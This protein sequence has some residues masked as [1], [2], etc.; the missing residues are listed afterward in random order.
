MM[1]TE[2]AVVLAGALTE[3]AIIGL[4]FY[5]HIWRILPFFCSYCI[6]DVFSNVTG[7]VIAH[8]NPATYF[9]VYFAQMIVDSVWLFCVLVEL[10]W[11]VLR[12]VRASLPRSAL[13]VVAALI[14]LVGAAIWPFAAISGLAHPASRQWLIMM[15]L[16]RTVA[17]LRVLFFFLLAAGSQLLSISWRD[18]ELQVATGLGFYSLVNVVVSI[19]QSHQ[20]TG[21][22]Y[23]RLNEFLIVSY[24]C[25]L[26]YWLVSFSQKEA[27][28]RE[29]TPQMQSF[30]L[31]MAGTARTTRIA[32]SDPRVNPARKHDKL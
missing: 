24:L 22:Q 28:R 2:N 21:S 10:A 17:I 16:Q 29:F 32:V 9:H 23:I 8:Y 6:W 4:L 20:S 27:E 18:R 30:L 7:D 19:L 11:S 25:S 12:P 3:I 31:A 14:L 1:S 5:R 26:F 15:Q 13:L